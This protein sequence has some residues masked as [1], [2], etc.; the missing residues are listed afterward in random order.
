MTDSTLQMYLPILM[1]VAT[2]TIILWKQFRKLRRITEPNPT[3]EK[4]REYNRLKKVS[5]YYWIIFSLFG[6]MTITYALIPEF[7]YVFLPLDKFH[8]PL[9]NVMGLLVMIIAIVWIIIA[10]IQIDKVFHKNSCNIENSSTIKLVRYSERILLLGMLVL[11]IG[12]FI[13]I[14][15]IIGLLLVGTGLAIYTN[16]FC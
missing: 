13:T 7:Y 6:I 16:V 14:T 12:L 8:H 1:L 9:I 2:W 11:F 4:V 3:I 5:G 10:Q 15:N